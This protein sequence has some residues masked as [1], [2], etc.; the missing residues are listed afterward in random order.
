[1]KIFVD[2][3]IPSMT[4]QALIQL[5]HEVKDIRGTQKEELSDAAL[6]EIVQTEKSLLITADKGFSQYRNDSHHGILIVRLKQ[7]NQDKFISGSCKH[8][9]IFFLEMIVI[10]FSQIFAARSFAENTRNLRK[11]R[12]RLKRHSAFG[13]MGLD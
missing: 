9:K 10:F 4:V 8:S 2:E 6:W 12:R 5:G 1:M 3:N 11:Y 7:P 13:K